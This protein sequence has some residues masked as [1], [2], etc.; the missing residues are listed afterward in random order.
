[1]SCFLAASPIGVLFG[2][3]LTTQLIINFTWKYAFYVQAIA[4]VPA[5]ILILVI[6]KRYFSLKKLS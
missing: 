5:I 4:V 6:P 1:M 3:V 2:Y